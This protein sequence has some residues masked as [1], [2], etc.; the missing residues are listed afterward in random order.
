M[1][2]IK[3]GYYDC[4]Y[5]LADKT[6]Y[7]HFVSDETIFEIENGASEHEKIFTYNQPVSFFENLN[8]CMIDNDYY[9]I[10]KKKIADGNMTEITCEIDPLMSY[11]DLI[12]DSTQ[13]VTRNAKKRN[14]YLVDNE[15]T[16]T[17]Y[18]L[19]DCYEFPNAINNDSIILITVG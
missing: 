5:L 6:N 12:Y 9:F 19:I 1:A 13:L 4:D 14:A 15:M 2:T 3:V 18:D 17:N 11:K 8:Y 7:I 10:T 16:F